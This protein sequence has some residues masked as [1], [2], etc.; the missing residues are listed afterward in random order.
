MNKI[1]NI[2]RKIYLLF[3][4]NKK[5]LK[6]EICEFRDEKCIFRKQINVFFDQ[7][8]NKE[9]GENEEM[10]MFLR[11]FHFPTNFCNDI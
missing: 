1:G 3:F 5:S 6:S 4:I 2:I 9:N 8:E 10:C 11:K 7:V